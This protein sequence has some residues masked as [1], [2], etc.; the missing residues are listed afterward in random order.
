[1]ATDK[2]TD[3]VPQVD[4]C[5][6]A[7]ITQRIVNECMLTVIHELVLETHRKEKMLLQT[8]HP[9]TRLPMCSSCNLPRLLDPPLAQSISSKNTQYC[10]HVP[11]STKP[12]HDIYGNPFPVAGSDKPPTKKERE[13]R[14]KAESNTPTSKNGR[15]GK[16]GT[17]ASQ[18][19]NGTAPPS[20]S[21]ENNS[22]PNTGAGPVDKKAAKVGERLNKGTYIPWHTCPSCKR[23]LLITRFAQHLEK[24]LGIGGRAA[25][26]AAA[27]IN[28]S[29]ANGTPAGSRGATPVPGSKNSKTGDAVAGA[30]ED[31]DE[32]VKPGGMKKKLLKRGLKQ[33]VKKAE[34]STPTSAGAGGGGKDKDKDAASGKRPPK[35]ASAEGKRDRDELG[36][37]EDDTPVRKK[38]RLQRMGST[39]SIMS[40]AS[41]NKEGSVDGSF[42]DD[43][44]DEE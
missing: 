35:N 32:I 33:S 23:S 42:V 26:R 37:D 5:D 43:S 34:R 13:A 3:T 8:L 27:R 4:K 2:S 40:T 22:Q 10:T 16:D 24:C 41:L 17:P 15:G 1:M 6:L 29:G 21:A 36:A 38:M 30:E 18:D 7:S 11:W 14:L 39:A 9:T 20:P 44:G 25:G 19:N 28:A 31:E 12:G